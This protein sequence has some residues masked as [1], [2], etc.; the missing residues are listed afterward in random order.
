MGHCLGICQK[1]NSEP[2][3]N[4]LRRSYEFNRVNALNKISVAALNIKGIFLTDLFRFNPNMGEIQ[5]VRK[6]GSDLPTSFAECQENQY[7]FPGSLKQRDTTRRYRHWSRRLGMGFRSAF[8]RRNSP[9]GQPVVRLRMGDVDGGCGRGVGYKWVEEHGPSRMVQSNDGDQMFIRSPEVS[10]LCGLESYDPNGY[11][12]FI[13]SSVLCFIN[14][15]AN[16]DTSELKHRDS[17]KTMHR[18]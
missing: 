18:K 14:L 17:T 16:L 15:C 9:E 5:T 11:H 4:H 10:Y 12:V 6:R 3:Y 7:F 2:K 13:G 8:G 1:Q